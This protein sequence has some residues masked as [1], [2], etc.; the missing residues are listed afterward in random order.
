MSK[1]APLILFFV[2]SIQSAIADSVPEKTL[3]PDSI[4]Q[5]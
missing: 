4:T 3:M 2:I 5:L 1:T